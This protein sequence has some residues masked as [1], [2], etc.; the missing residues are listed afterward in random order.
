[1]FEV[2][3]SIEVSVDQ[4]NQR[5]SWDINGGMVG[6]HHVANTLKYKSCLSCQEIKGNNEH[7]LDSLFLVL[8]ACQ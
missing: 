2:Y 6:A 1:M 7:V 4:F 8:H 3:E 5:V